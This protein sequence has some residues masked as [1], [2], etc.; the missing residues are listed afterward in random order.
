M[1]RILL[2]ITF[3]ALTGNCLCNLS[4]DLFDAVLNNDLKE[5]K[6][7]VKKGAQINV[8]NKNK[9]IPLHIAA[10]F[11]PDVV[12][13]LVKKGADVNA[14]TREEKTPLA[15]AV[16]VGLVGL[17]TVKFLV[18][19]L[20]IINRWDVGNSKNKV[21]Y[22]FLEKIFAVQGL[23]DKELKSEISKAIKSKDKDLLPYLLI[24]SLNKIVDKINESKAVIPSFAGT[25]IRDFYKKMKNVQNKK[26]IAGIIA[27]ELEIDPKSIDFSTTF[28]SFLKKA[29]KAIIDSGHSIAPKAKKALKKLG[30]YRSK[31]FEERM[32]FM[33]KETF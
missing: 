15:D 16:E 26:E 13:F 9:E 14:K 4:D 25:L 6:S 7:L 12:K 19:N 27:K 11:G 18:L 31:D 17:D 10:M 2:T 32:E 3:L 30:G 24:V 20:A 21:Y 33:I 8:K 23:T 22:E 1:K 5:V 28:K 29:L